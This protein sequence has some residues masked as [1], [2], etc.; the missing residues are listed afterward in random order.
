[1]Q[2]YALA[3]TNDS[4]YWRVPLDSTAT[5]DTAFRLHDGAL[6]SGRLA[7]S[8]AA[9]AGTTRGRETPHVLHGT[10]PLH[11]TDYSRVADGPAG[12]FRYLLV[13]AR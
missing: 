4:S 2:G 5:I 3:L 12:T 13:E 6:L 10:Y 9:G 11:W 1:V 8:A 7:W